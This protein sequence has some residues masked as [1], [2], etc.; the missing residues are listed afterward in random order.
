VRA[1]AVHRPARCRWQLPALV[2][3]AGLA[4]ALPS[5]GV[6]GAIAGRPSRLG[7]IRLRGAA[8][9]EAVALTFD[10]GPSPEGTPR[11]LHRLEQ[12]GLRATFFVT[13]TE[14]ARHP[15]LV[16]DIRSAGHGVESHGM[17][18]RHHLL[19]GPRWVERDLRAALDVLRSLGVRP[20]Y[21]RPPYGQAA[22]A[23]LVAAQRHRLG[24]VLWSC[25]GREFAE[26]RAAAVAARI[27]QR[28]EP[29]A[30]VLLHDSDQHCGP[31][32]VAAVDQALEA[33]AQELARRRL[34]SVRLAELLE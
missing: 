31:G 34:R 17:E 23:T 16:A 2:G 28:L 12:L 10:D 20:R 11:I 32:S 30:I 5:V 18:H 14:A 27:R 7:P 13:G 21:L 4:H 15:A 25:W 26:P 29:G 33:V 1:G 19:H 6:L 9:T 24:C 3:A 8:G 22:A